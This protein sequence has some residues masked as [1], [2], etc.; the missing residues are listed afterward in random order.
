MAFDFWAFVCLLFYLE[1]GEVLVLIGIVDLV[2]VHRHLVQNAKAN[3]GIAPSKVP[4][5]TWESL[6]KFF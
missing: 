3:M 5:P 4:R 2:C 1:C 6:G